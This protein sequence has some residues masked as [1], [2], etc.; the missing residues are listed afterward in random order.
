MTKVSSQ[1]EEAMLEAA[2]RAEL[3]A[4]FSI[5]ANF[6]QSILKQFLTEDL[7]SM[8]TFIYGAAEEVRIMQ[9]FDFLI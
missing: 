7:Y 8:F 6:S 2:K 1:E 3:R 5:Q 4:T 9:L